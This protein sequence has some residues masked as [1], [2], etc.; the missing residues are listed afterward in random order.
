MKLLRRKFLHLAAGAAALSAVSRIARA[1]T[2][3][4]R[5]VRLIVG[6]P[7][8][9]DISMAGLFDHLVGTLENR[10]RNRNAN[11]FGCFQIDRQL[12]PRRLLE[13]HVGRLC[14]F[15]DSGH[16]AGSAA[17]AVRPIRA[18]GD[19]PARSGVVR[20]SINGR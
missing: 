6:A 2:Y 12:E 11:A 1:Q 17:K 5:P 3:P 20:T 8:G 19:E 10:W 13:R 15:E 7:P 16:K 18:V 4:T 14:A 9:L